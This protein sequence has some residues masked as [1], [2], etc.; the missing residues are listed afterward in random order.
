MSKYKNMETSEIRK[1]TEVLQKINTQC[2]GK[3]RIHKSTE[4]INVKN[5]AFNVVEEI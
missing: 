4:N 3:E 2:T 1:R 5:N